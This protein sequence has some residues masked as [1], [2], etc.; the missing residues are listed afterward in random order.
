MDYIKLLKKV[1]EDVR[2]SELSVIVR[3][4]EMEIGSHVAIDMWTYISPKAILGSYI[5]IAPNVSIIGGASALITMGDFT[6]IASGCRIICA[7]DDFLQ[8]LISPVVPMEY[9]TIINKPV[10]F[11]RY[12][13]LGVNCAVLPGVIL[14]EGS[15]VGANSVVTKNTEPWTVYAGSPAKPIKKRDSK[16][17]L[18]SGK[19]L[20]NYE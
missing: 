19:K 13:T 18:E 9:R 5:H 6:N 8:G 10:T 2:I 14:G 12:S 1:G 7:G 20:M 15:I 17:I 11:E 16:R 3:P 4:E